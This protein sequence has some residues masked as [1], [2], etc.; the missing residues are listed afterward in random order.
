MLGL[1]TTTREPG[2]APTRPGLAA[3]RAGGNCTPVMGGAIWLERGRVGAWCEGSGTGREVMT[4]G[5][6]LFLTTSLGL[7]LDR[8]SVV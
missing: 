1:A 4:G 2:L 8:K 7:F 6:L 5:R 3:R